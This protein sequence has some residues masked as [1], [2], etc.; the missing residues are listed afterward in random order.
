M[1]N[2]DLEKYLEEKM[3]DEQR[4]ALYVNLA[5]AY[6]QT[7]NNINERYLGMLKETTKTLKMINKKLSR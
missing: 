3:T 6:I 2:K 7:M 1:Q 5:L 4:G